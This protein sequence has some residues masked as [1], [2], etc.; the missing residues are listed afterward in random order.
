MSMGMSVSAPRR[1]PVA[2]VTG[3]YGLIALIQ[4]PKA[5]KQRLDELTKAEDEAVEAYDRAI[6][7]QAA[8]EAAEKKAVAAGERSEAAQA[9]TEKVKQDGE[10]KLTYETQKLSADRRQ[11]DED[12]ADFSGR[13]KTFNEHVAKWEAEEKARQDTL[14]RR[15]R[16]IQ[17]LEAEA[18]DKLATAEGM[19]ADAERRIGL[20][21]SAAA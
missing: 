19:M 6:K 15:E 21:R 20:I 14:G 1:M 11:L 10:A 2:E 17:K 3:L 18:K 4:D 13:V 5:A 7:A 12:R 8:A 16:G 9:A